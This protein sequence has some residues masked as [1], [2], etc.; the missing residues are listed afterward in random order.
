VEIVDLNNSKEGYTPYIGSNILEPHSRLD[1]EDI[2]IRQYLHLPSSDDQRLRS[3]VETAQDQIH[4][5]HVK[6]IVYSTD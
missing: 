6:Y 1:F 4:V 5:V 2:I 3:K